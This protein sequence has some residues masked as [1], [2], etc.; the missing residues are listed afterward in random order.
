MCDEFLLQRVRERLDHHRNHYLD[1]HREIFELRLIGKLRV[2][3]ISRD[4][5]MQE[6]ILHHLVMDDYR[7]RRNEDN[8][9]PHS[10]E[11]QERLVT[12]LQSANVTVIETRQEHAASDAG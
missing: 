3:R 11:I 8:Y 1:W 10:D 2:S 5:T 6:H 9:G 4:L 12:A 7:Q